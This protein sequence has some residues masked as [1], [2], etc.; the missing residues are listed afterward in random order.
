[1]SKAKKEMKQCPVCKTISLQLVTVIGDGTM[2]KCGYC[3]YFSD[4]FMIQGETVDFLYS[5]HIEP[6]FATHMI[7]DD[8]EK[9]NESIREQA[10]DLW[11]KAAIAAIDNGVSNA[12]TPGK[13]ANATVNAF[14]KRYIVKPVVLKEHK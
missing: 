9:N 6:Y 4:S 3:K 11:K 2:F 10:T 7:A 14:L 1:M 13:I 5:Q 8:S 12:E